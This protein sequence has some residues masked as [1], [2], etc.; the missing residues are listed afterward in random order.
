MCMNVT[1]TGRNRCSFVSCTGAR[2][3]IW[4]QEEVYCADT[5]VYFWADRSC[6]C[7]S[8]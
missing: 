5:G 8:A 7:W 6:T 1:P 3:D 2:G 4:Y